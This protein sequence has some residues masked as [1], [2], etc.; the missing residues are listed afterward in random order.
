MMTIAIIICAALL[1]AFAIYSTI[2]RARGKNRSSCCGTPEVKTVRKVEDT[3]RAHYPYEY[4]IGI[5][6]MM[7]SNCA[8][9]VENKLNGVKGLWASV[10]LAKH[11]ANVMAK[12]TMCERDIEEALRGT[13]YKVTSFM[14]KGG[15]N[16]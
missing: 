2:N 15:E 12:Q 14:E 9:T 5:D 16:G 3:D 6:G 4:E 11:K 10:D 1:V 7:C 13:K 8:G